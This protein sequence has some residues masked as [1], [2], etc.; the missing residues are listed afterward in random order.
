MQPLIQI[1]AK[2]LRRDSDG[3]RS[4]RGAIGRIAEAVGQR[5]IYLDVLS[6]RDTPSVIGA[7]ELSGIHQQ[8]LM[9]GIDFV[10]VMTAGV[11]KPL[12]A[13]A[14]TAKRSGVGALI[15][16]RMTRPDPGRLGWR[17]LLSK[18]LDALGIGVAEADLMLDLEFLEPSVVIK[19]EQI[20][21]V[22]ELASAV[23]PWRTVTVNGTS[24]PSS[25]AQYSRAE[26]TPLHRIEWSLFQSVADDA[27][28]PIGFGDHAIQG[29]R[30][31]KSG[32]R[33]PIP[34]IRY[35]HEAATWV[36]L[37]TATVARLGVP[38]A[39]REYVRLCQMVLGQLA[40]SGRDYS[41]GDALME[42]CARGLLQAEGQTMWRGVG[43]SHHLTTVAYQLQERD[44]ATAIRLTRSAQTVQQ[45]QP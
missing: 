33:G 26:L 25:L 37:G 36:A 24:M 22:L 2:R 42:D 34:N 23:G 40:S 21:D 38:E 13:V 28:R 8:A 30:S 5:R 7:S 1:E 35:T 41:W 15:R 9:A 19:P 10:P 17:A 16:L 4:T 39:R 11:R 44:L 31:P 27:H 45:T 20:R 32:G 18:E 29:P 14:A 3:L 12:D 6:P 43:T